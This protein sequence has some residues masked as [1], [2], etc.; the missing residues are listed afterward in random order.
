VLSSIT[1]VILPIIGQHS[2]Y[3]LS[4][5]PAFFTIVSVVCAFLATVRLLPLEDIRETV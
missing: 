4:A 5:Y 1:P 3:L 2:P